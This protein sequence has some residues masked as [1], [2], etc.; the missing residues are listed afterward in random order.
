MSRIFVISDLHLGHNNLAKHR[1][2]E[3]AES[4]DE[5]IVAQWNSVITKRD[6]VWVLGDI[7]MEHHKHY[8]KLN[9]LN[10]IKN[11]VGGNHDS[12]KH[13][14]RM[15][16]YINKYCGCFNYKGLILTHIPIHDSCLEGRFK[17]NIHGHIHEFNIHD[18]RYVNVSAEKLDYKPTLISKFL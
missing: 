6:T 1:G 13:T 10:G 7:T 15:M 14:K 8:P 11:I 2:F 17:K 18:D 4:Q 16:E 3:D 9:L 5:Y 12:P